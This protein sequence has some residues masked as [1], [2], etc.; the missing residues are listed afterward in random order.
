MNPCAPW[1]FF[2]FIFR[3]RVT[4]GGKQWWKY[5]LLDLFHRGLLPI[6]II[7]TIII[8]IIIIIIVVVVVVVIIII[9]I[10]IIIIII[11]ISKGFLKLSTIKIN[12]K[13]RRF[14][15]ASVIIKWMVKI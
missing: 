6:R 9:I 14:D 10:V 7:I 5:A 11:I 1:L 13:T 15:R 2:Q 12:G 4:R 3:F 8:I